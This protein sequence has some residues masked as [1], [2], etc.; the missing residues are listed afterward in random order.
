M[1]YILN[2]LKKAER[3]RLR[4]DPKNLDEFA[5]ASWDP[6]SEPEKK[7]NTPVY[8]LLA[9]LLSVVVIAGYL[10]VTTSPRQVTLPS[11]GTKQNAETKEPESMVPTNLPAVEQQGFDSGVRELDRPQERTEPDSVPQVP[12]VVITGHLFLGESSSLNRVF[13]ADKS[14]QSG[15]S[16]NS[17]WYIVSIGE[18]GIL[19]SSGDREHHISYR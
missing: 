13:I 3:E 17:D 8:I 10:Y 1:S 2:A 16:I 5:T 15:D 6:Y 9:L 11:T 7:G 12:E 19:I 4:E 14:Y 18:G